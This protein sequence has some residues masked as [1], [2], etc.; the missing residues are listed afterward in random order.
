MSQHLEEEFNESEKLRQKLEKKAER[1]KQNLPSEQQEQLRILEGF[2]ALNADVQEAK[3]FQRLSNIVDLTVLTSQLTEKLAEFNIDING[4]SNILD[5]V[6]TAL[7]GVQGELSTLTV[8]VSLE[9]EERKKLR[10]KQIATL[11]KINDYLEKW[12]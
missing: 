5:S 7:N 2:L 9:F 6:V 4:Q 11:Q 1:R 10:Q 12:S 3:A 8:K